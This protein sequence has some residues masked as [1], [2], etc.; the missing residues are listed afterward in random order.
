MFKAENERCICR[1]GN[2]KRTERAFVLTIFEPFQ[3]GKR[4]KKRQ[5]QEFSRGSSESVRIGGRRVPLEYAIEAT[6]F[7]KKREKGKKK[8]IIFFR[9][10]GLVPGQAERK[11][12]Q[13]HGNWR[14]NCN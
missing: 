2:L 13:I 1:K 3:I 4:S 7:G 12:I 5:K 11:L 8:I 10:S 14:A 9:S 6:R